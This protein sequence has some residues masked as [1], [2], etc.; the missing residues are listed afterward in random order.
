MRLL[1]FWWFWVTIALIIFIILVVVFGPK[2]LAFLVAPVA[3]LFSMGA[4]TLGADRQQSRGSRPRRGGTGGSPTKRRGVIK[5]ETETSN[6]G[7][8]NWVAPAPLPNRPVRPG[9]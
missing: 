2:A 1:K 7:Q 9:F 8:D 6:G 4:V 5:S 3:A